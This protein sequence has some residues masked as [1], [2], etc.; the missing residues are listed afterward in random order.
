MAYNFSQFQSKMKETE[1]WL[2]REFS[3]L[4]TGRATPAILDVV[5]VE[6]YGSR[7]P[8]NQ[9]A[10]VHV[11]DAR[12]IRIAPWDPTQ[13]KGIETAI[14]NADLGLSVNVDDKGLRVIF[15]ELTSERRQQLIKVAKSKLEDARVAI[16][17]ERE[18]TWDDIQKKEKAGEM[19][20]DDKFRLKEQMQKMV[21][22][23]NKSLDELSAKKEQEI[24]Q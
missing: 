3:G 22:D 5:S 16:R 21:D 13:I 12:S 8:I 23:A 1:E 24:N 7:M 4:R 10:N 6:S 18:R 11:E 19:S 2:K 14:K 9:L 20:E 17:A 15:P